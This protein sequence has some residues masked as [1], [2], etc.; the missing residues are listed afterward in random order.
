[1]W[2][3]SWPVGSGP[4]SPESSSLRVPLGAAHPAPGALP[5]SLPPRKMLLKNGRRNKAARPWRVCPEYE[6]VRGP[7]SFS[8]LAPSLVPELP[9][10][11]LDPT[12]HGKQQGGGEETNS[13]NTRWLLGASV[14]TTLPRRPLKRSGRYS[15]NMAIA[16]PFWDPLFG[17]CQQS[18][19][20]ISKCPQL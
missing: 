17:N 2:G 13:R 1:M 12:G 20:L 11:N 4:P 7:F 10:A 16:Q 5:S 14:A 18:L 15:S 6:Y 9:G 3:W 19:S 8:A